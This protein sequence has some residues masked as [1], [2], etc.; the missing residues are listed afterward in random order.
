MLIIVS[1][2]F[3]GEGTAENPY[4]ITDYEDLKCVSDMINDKL[5]NP[6]FKN[7]YYKQTTDIDM[8]HQEFVPIGS[9]ENSTS[10]VFSGNYNGNYHEI[11]NLS[12]V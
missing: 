11:T 9:G 5:T 3:D 12:S 4:L 7:A 10:A 8:N 1:V 6:H 2:T